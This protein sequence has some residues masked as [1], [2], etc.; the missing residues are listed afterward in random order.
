MLKFHK[1]MEL[2]IEAVLEQRQRGWS[3]E[4]ICN[5]RCWK[6]GSHGKG[7]GTIQGQPGLQVVLM[8]RGGNSPETFYAINTHGVATLCKH[9][10]RLWRH[11]D[12]KEWLQRHFQSWWVRQ[13]RSTLPFRRQMELMKLDLGCGPWTFFGQRS[14]NEHATCLPL[15]SP[16]C[17]PQRKMQHLFV[18]QK[19]QP[20]TA[21]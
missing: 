10:A 15:V 5:G 2:A 8:E 4:C 1:S 3:A 19:G 13:T 21:L 6:D 12:G 9:C 18:P 20:E 11:R 16:P 7:S 14:G 17:P